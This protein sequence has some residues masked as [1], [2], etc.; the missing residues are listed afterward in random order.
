MLVL[1]FIALL[2]VAA[3][4]ACVIGWLFTRRQSYLVWAWR[5]AKAVVVAGLAIVG[6]LL[7]ERLIVL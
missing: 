2:A 4:V 1:R 5:I 7:M 3:I 6:L